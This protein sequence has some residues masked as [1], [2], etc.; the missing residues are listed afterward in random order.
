MTDYHPRLPL[1]VYTADKVLIGE[2]GEE[3]RNVVRL[4]DIPEVMKR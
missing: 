1:R 2:Y 4:A 3:H